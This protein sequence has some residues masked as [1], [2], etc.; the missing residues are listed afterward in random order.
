MA[1]NVGIV[2]MNIGSGRVIYLVVPSAI[3]D[4]FGIV[5]SEAPAEAFLRKKKAHTR[6]VR[7]RQV[8]NDTVI[9]TVAVKSSEW[10]D[11]RNRNSGGI[12]GKLIKIPTQLRAD[13]AVPTS[14]IRL[15][16]MRVPAAASN[17]AIAQWIKTKFVSKKPT[18][19]ITS[20]GVL[21]PTNVPSQ[22]DPNPGNT[23]PAP[24]P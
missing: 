7:S 23:A 1:Q 16:S 22:A 14:P 4:Y 17:Y 2:D 8:L 3:I 19:Y 10:Y 6:K 12:I 11:T 5:Q 9:E 21:Y 15:V 13:P 20:G 18:Y 24:A